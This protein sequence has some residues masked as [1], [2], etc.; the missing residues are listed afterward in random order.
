MSH[1]SMINHSNGQATESSPSLLRRFRQERDRR[2]TDSLPGVLLLALRADL[3]L[4]LT[5]P[6]IIGA[7]V[8]GWWV[9]VFDWV[10]FSFAVASVLLSAVAFQ[11]LSAWQDYQQS[12]R[13]DARPATDAPDSPFTL[14][15][16]GVLPPSLLLNLGALLYTIAILCGLW[17]A[18]L[19]GWPILF[20]GVIAMLLQLA[21]V[22]PPLRYAYRGYALG[23]LGIFTAFGLLPLLSAFYAQ[24]QQL[25][26]LPILGGL[27]ISILALLVVLSQN[28]ATLRRDWLIGKRTLAVILEAPRTV[29]FNAF[30]TML[31]YTA[32]LA[33]T[34]VGRLPLW[35]LGGLATLPLAMGAFA[36]IDRNQTTPDD[37]VRL[38]STATKAV[39]WTAVL[40]IAALLISRPG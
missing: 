27:P 1:H 20:F 9:G 4:A 37:A 34:V 32:I 36:E 25:S 23:E 33:V 40:L 7:A 39:F 26:W 11:V 38:R 22:A 31:A 21:A 29:D 13:A 12:L 8:G 16:N 5:L 6:T 3:A 28:L 18:L 15:Q 10:L 30:L 2:L 19:A 17:L 35:Y 14:Q 24:T